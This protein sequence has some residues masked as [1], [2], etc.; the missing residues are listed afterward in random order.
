MTR[1]TKPMWSMLIYPNRK[2]TR[3]RVESESLVTKGGWEDTHVETSKDTEE[4]RSRPSVN[5]QHSGC[6]MCMC[7]GAKLLNISAE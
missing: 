2:R 3:M 7:P 5:A 1:V 4:R 6:K